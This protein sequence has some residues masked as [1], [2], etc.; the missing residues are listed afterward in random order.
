MPSPVTQFPGIPPP[1]DLDG[2]WCELAGVV[3][4]VNAN[5]TISVVGNQGPIC[6][7]IGHTPAGLLNRLVDARL[8]A[9][10]V[11]SLTLLEVPV[12]LVPTPKFVD[13]EEEPPD[14][15]F[16]MPAS[17]IANLFPEVVKSTP[18]RRARVVGEIT[19]REPGWFFLQDASGGIR[20]RTSALPAAKVGDT[21]EVLAFPALNNFVHTLTEP[22]LRPVRAAA[23]VSPRD[24]DLS[25]GLSVK[26][27]DMLVRVRATLLGRKSNGISQVL[28]LQEQQRFFTATLAAD[29]GRLPD[30]VPGSRLRLTGVCD[31]VAGAIPAIG[32]KPPGPQM[33]TSLN[34]LLR[35]PNDVAVLGGP[36]WWNWKR[37]TTLVGTLLAILIVTLLWVHLLQRRLERQ[38]AAQL[39]FTRQ[40]LERLEDERRRI[41]INLHD[42]LGQILLAIKNQAVLALQRPPDETGLR[43][44]LDEI[45]GASSQA[46]EE[47]RQV[48]QGLRPYQLDR[49]GLTQTIR[50]VVARAAESGS[51]QFA[52]R[53][54]NID[55]VFDKEAE[56]HVYRI[57]Q[58]AV[59]NVIK[60]SAATEATVVVKRRPSVVSVSI[61]DNGRG[62]EVG[63][64]DSA[65]PSGAGSG[66]S[67]IAERVRILNGTLA[68]DSRPGAGTSLTV[69]V[70]LSPHANESGNNSPHRG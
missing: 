43:Q 48:T 45:S 5:G 25:E 40:M 18:P 66:L 15:P 34:I 14:D 39:A 24:L 41:A 56:I 29:H 37:T 57:V 26:Q 64:V 4:S 70:S 9:R 62:F 33:L 22:L 7:W 67:G 47:V 49:L 55:G 52:C 61:R 63:T 21:V 1:P 36:P 13:V 3:H 42:S 54:E 60:H 59:N 28:E 69:E 46:I 12:L 44:R 16:N 51:I 32:E 8:R 30:F 53:V 35:S 65:S 68:V 6:F 10:G 11:L 50:A 20:V 2:K 38:R 58:E 19:C 31:N 17:S 23:P 27:S